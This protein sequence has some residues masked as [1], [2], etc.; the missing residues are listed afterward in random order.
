[1]QT[2][3]HLSRGKHLAYCTFSVCVCIAV[4]LCGHPCVHADF[5]GRVRLGTYAFALP[6]LQKQSTRTQHT[7][8]CMDTHTHAQVQKHAVTV[9][10]TPAFNQ[11][12]HDANHDTNT[13][14]AMHAHTHTHMRAHT[15][16][17]THTGTSM[18]TYPHPPIHTR[19]HTSSYAR[20]C[21]NRQAHLHPRT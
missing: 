2:Q 19:A 14:T 7:G 8:K 20:T 17:F 10:S 21:T 9:M 15:C 6:C 11:V 3:V 13:R 4:C 12:K 18:H 16:M 1:M 5:L